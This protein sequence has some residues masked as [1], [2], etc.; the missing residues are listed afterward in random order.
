VNYAELAK[1]KKRVGEDKFPLIPMKYHPNG[2]LG[3]KKV[4][5]PNKYPSVIKSTSPNQ[6]H[7]HQQTVGSTHAGFG[8][9]IARTEAE[10]FDV[11]GIVALNSD[12]FT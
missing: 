5:I 4:L 7:T 6:L 10:Y 11:E 3:T 1:I 2:Y 12:Y 9:M 8:K